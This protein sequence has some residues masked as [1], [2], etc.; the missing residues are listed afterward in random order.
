MKKVTTYHIDITCIERDD[1]V[2]F[3]DM[4]LSRLKNL[5]KHGMGEGIGI[6]HYRECPN[7]GT[8][9]IQIPKPSNQ[10]MEG[11]L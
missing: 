6:M 11:K 2:L 8:K 5:A 1:A 10:K 3:R 9:P 4:C 7:P